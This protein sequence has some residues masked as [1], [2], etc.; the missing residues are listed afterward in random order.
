MKKASKESRSSVAE[1]KFK[2]KK[3]DG[4]RLMICEN[5]VPSGK[6]WR[7][8]V[9][10]TWE[11]VS[12]DAVSVLCHKC[13]MGMVE[14]PKERVFAEKSDKP[15][16]WKFMKEYV[17]VEGNV[18]HK[19]IV[20]PSLFGTLEPT[21][22]EPKEEKKKMSRKEKEELLTSVGSDVAALKSKLFSESRKGERAKITKE[23][24]Q[25]TRQLKKL[26]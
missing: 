26:I 15:K 11:R 1:S 7:N 14:P 23:L 13:I 4:L 6:Y 19:G 25:K 20:Q 18:Y 5:S 10:D 16:G 8:I 9:C 21:V 17:D 12:N 24:N 2:T 3:V 22:I